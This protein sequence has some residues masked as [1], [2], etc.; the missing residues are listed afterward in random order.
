MK[1]II[2]AGGL[3]TRLYPLTHTNNKHLLPV[4]DK[5]MIYYPIQTLVKAG[6]KEILIITSGPYAGNVVNLLK[7]GEGLG[8]DRL[9]YSYKEGGTLAALSSVKQFAE[10]DTV[11]VIY[12]D[13]ITD[14]DISRHARNFKRGAMIFLKKVKDPREFGVAV[15]DKNN[16]KRISFIEEKPQKFSSNL[17]VTG[18]Y[19]FDNNIFNQM[20]QAKRSERENFNMTDALNNYL[21]KGELNW[22][23][24]KGFWSDAGTFE[25]LSEANQYWA[26]K[27]AKQQRS[28]SV[29][30]RNAS[31]SAPA[32]PAFLG[33][34][35]AFSTQ[36]DLL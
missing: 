29:F 30:S 32:A 18:I 1:G 2:I 36:A 34:K 23:L 28:S 22:T 35:P 31:Q 13:N 7:D 11:A 25:G 3:G 15:F 20:F 12:G 33:S 24:L 14:A 21:Q 10:G 6:I 17:A 8:V 4:F 19:L 9:E 16:R 26:E 5:P 27:H